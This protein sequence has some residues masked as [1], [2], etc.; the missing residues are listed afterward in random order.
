MRIKYILDA[1][2]GEMILALRAARSALKHPSFTNAVIAFGDSKEG[3]TI[4]FFV[5]RNKASVSVK[6]ISRAD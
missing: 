1:E 5:K 4:D 2:D 6:Q 3:Q